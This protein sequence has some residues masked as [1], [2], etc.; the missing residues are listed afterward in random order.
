[1]NQ[2]SFAPGRIEL[3]GHSGN[4]DQNLVLSAAINLGVKACGCARPDERIILSSS[5][6]HDATYFGEPMFLE[7]KHNWA[8]YP[9]GVAKVLALSGYRIH[10]FDF[11]Y[12]S[13]LPSGL[14]LCSSSAF[15]VA[16]IILLSK[17]FDLDIP[18]A[19]IARICRIAER[20]FIS[21]NS[22][23]HDHAASIFGKHDYLMLV[24]DRRES[25]VHMPAGADLAI[26]ILSV[27]GTSLRHTGS[28]QSTSHSDDDVLAGMGFLRQGDIESF[29]RL[30][31][32]SCRE[33]S[34]SQELD[35]LR[36][37][38]TATKGIYGA[39]LTNGAA[40][41]AVIALAD[42]R[43]SK[44]ASKHILSKYASLTSQKA[45]SHHCMISSGAVSGAVPAKAARSNPREACLALS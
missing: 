18:P 33:P 37:L 45:V 44:D 31:T 17:I 9:F 40:G 2:S 24:D 43:Q 16:T 10:G 42:V 19:E 23:M 8:D 36:S 26:L 6:H 22:R 21:I 1:M 30:M 7:P 27:K 4:F 13:T 5:G 12:E 20:E 3:L 11:H 28:F 15:E 14:G 32:N 38:A 34:G 35:T 41:G 29:G 39:R 25:V